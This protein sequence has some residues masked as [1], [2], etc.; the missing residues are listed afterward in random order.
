[1]I[2]NTEVFLFF[3]DKWHALE[4][5]D[6]VPFPL[7]YNIADISDITKRNTTFSKTLEFPCTKNNDEVFG[8]IFDI[9]SISNFNINKKVKCTVVAETVPVLKEAFLQ[10]TKIKTTDN[11]HYYYECVIF[12]DADNLIKDM[13]SKLMTDIDVSELNHIYSRANM[14]GSW[15]AS[16]NRGYYY[17]LADL[18]NGYTSINIGASSSGSGVPL[19]QMYPTP[20]VKYLFYKLMSDNG[21]SVDSDWVK[22]DETFENSYILTGQIPEPPATF[23]AFNTFKAGLSQSITISTGPRIWG[24][25]GGGGQPCVATNSIF[26]GNPMGVHTTT[27]H[28]QVAS[29]IFPILGD[30]RAQLLQRL[31]TNS[32]PFPFDDDFSGENFDPGNNFSIIS[33]KYKCGPNPNP[34]DFTFNLDIEFPSDAFLQLRN[35]EILIQ[36][37]WFRSTYP[38]TTGPQSVIIPTTDYPQSVTYPVARFNPGEVPFMGFTGWNNPGGGIWA[39]VNGPNSGLHPSASNFIQPILPGTRVSMSS[40]STVIGHPD[41]V[42]FNRYPPEPFEEF[43]VGL[44]IFAYMLDNNSGKTAS[45]GPSFSFTIHNIGLDGVERTFLT[46]NINKVLAPDISYIGAKSFIPKTMKQVDFFTSIVKQFNLYVE[47]DKFIPKRLKIE[48]RDNYYT[49]GKTK[50]WTEKVAIDKEV[51][52][53]LIAEGQNKQ[54]ILTYKQDKDGYSQRWFDNNKTIY[55]QYKYTLDNEFSKGETKIESVFASTPVANIPGMKLIVPYIYKDQN[56]NSKIDSFIPRFLQRNVNGVINIPSQTNYWKLAGQTFSYYPYLGH[57]NHDYFP[58]SDLNFGEYM[59]YYQLPADIS[60]DQLSNNNLFQKYYKRQLDEFTN[61]ESRIITLY[62]KLT[63]QD[64]NE[65]SFSDIIQLDEVS[66]GTTNYFRV[67]K[68][69]YDPTLKGPF[70]VELLKLIY[71]GKEVVKADTSTDR[72]YIT[73]YL[74]LIAG[75]NNN[76]NVNPTAVI[77]GNN[78]ELYGDV[79]NSIITGNNNIIYQSP[80]TSLFGNYNDISSSNNLTL[81][82]ANGNTVSNTTDSIISGN[83]NIIGSASLITQNNYIFGN[84][85]VLNTGVTNSFI[86]GNNIT[87]TQSNSFIIGS[88]NFIIYSGTISY[89]NTHST[90]TYVEVTYTDLTTNLIPNGLL[91]PGRFYKIDTEQT[92]VDIDAGII[93]IATSLNEI[94]KYGTRYMLTPTTYDT[95]TLAGFDWL[96]VWNAA[97]TPAATNKV[98]WGG[99]VWSNLTGA[100]GTSTDPFNLDATNWVLSPKTL[101]SIDYIQMEMSVIYDVVNNW[102]EFQKDELGNEIGVDTGYFTNGLIN[103]NPCSVTDWNLKTLI[104]AAY[105]FNDNKCPNGI[106]NNITVNGIYRNICDSITNNNITGGIYRNINNSLVISDNTNV[107]INDNFTNGFIFNNSNTGSIGN[108]FTNGIS[109][110]SNGGAIIGN[111][112]KGTIVNNTNTGNINNNSNL[113]NISTNSNLGNITGNSNK[114]VINLNT[115]SVTMHI[116]YN[117]NAGGITSNTGVGTAISFNTNIGSISGNTSTS[118]ISNNSN[119][120]GITGNSNQGLIQFNMNNGPI[121]NNTSVASYDIINNINNGSISGAHVANVSDT[122]V[123]K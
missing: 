9:A 59:P 44:S 55:G 19:L 92:G 25:F 64:I 90:I 80:N 102:V 81:I 106:W 73:S 104:T 123:N 4:V 107:D 96:G 82:N 48:P 35:C 69:D 71:F 14:I 16:W 77:A 42:G 17:P 26:L 110:N 84:N 49:G 117:S 70:K 76:N 54:I 115:S 18:G 95:V 97:L 112:N 39:Y 2:N 13:G 36:A 83:N 27:G 24:G 103:Y 32:T 1:M 22:N 119:D 37:H 87:S 38:K 120:G 101:T 118:T 51:S 41:N 88:D 65:F 85:N 105:L 109:T 8:Y 15:T 40:N 61:K 67:N 75:N 5:K 29:G 47:Q 58:T 72:S 121:Q 12:G 7:T 53:D 50:N 23:S 6:T 46:N 52:Q 114:D 89:G 28:E 10:L 100:V 68:I 116:E 33:N 108:N 113:G 111:S 57:Y 98:V 21:W 63:S 94:S 66:S 86:V 31:G 20:S 91:I 34:M 78:N 56:F 45:V 74:G 3:D 30:T 62:M 99:Q 79:P 93:C 60:T 43:W 122:I 11:I